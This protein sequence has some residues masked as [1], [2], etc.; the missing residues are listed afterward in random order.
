MDTPF[1]GSG[2][3]IECAEVAIAC[4]HIKSSVADDGGRRNRHGDAPEGWNLRARG[5]VSG[6][7]GIKSHHLIQTGGIEIYDSIGY[8]GGGSHVVP[9]P[10]PDGSPGA[11]IPRG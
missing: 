4:A 2:G 11:R 7:G 10:V 9:A 1:G 6:L 8:R 3:G 5:G